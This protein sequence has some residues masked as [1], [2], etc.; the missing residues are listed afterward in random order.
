MHIL[1]KLIY[2][3]LL[4]LSPISALSQPCEAATF[5]GRNVTFPT[6]KT[7][8]YRNAAHLQKGVSAKPKGQSYA[9]MTFTGARF[10]TNLV[11][12]EQ[13]V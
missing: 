1:S 13:T 3:S 10:T 5:C 6:L 2:G 11:T 4:N 12:F 9:F 8:F 7:L